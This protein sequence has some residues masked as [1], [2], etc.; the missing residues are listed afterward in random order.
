MSICKFKERSRRWVAP[1]AGS[2]DRNFL[3]RNFRLS[4]SVA[5]LAGSVDRNKERSRRW[6]GSRDVAPL[7]G[8]VDRNAIHGVSL[9]PVSIV[10]PLAGSVDRNRVSKNTSM[11]KSVA[12]LA[13]SVDRNLCDP[14]AI[15][16][17]VISSLPSRGAWIEIIESFLRCSISAVAPLA[18]SVDR[19]KIRSSRCAAAGRRSPRGE[20]G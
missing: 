20:R 10:A 1:L 19:N 3:R 12:P 6:R 9:L 4:V 18:G 7:A 5:P 14:P 2:V 16:R 11:N 8:S 15:T 17:T 13:G